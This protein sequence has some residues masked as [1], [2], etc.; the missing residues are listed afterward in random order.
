MD[1]QDK[2]DIFSKQK[3]LVLLGPTACGK[4]A[5]SL[6]I[7]QAFQA[8][9]ISADSMQVYRCMDIGTAKI[10][11]EEMLG[12]PHHLLDIR[13]PN[14]TFSVADFREAAS[15]AIREIAMRGH[16]PFLVGGTGL[17][18]N[19]LLRPYHFPDEAAA[20]PALRE[21]LRKELAEQGNLAMHKR[22]AEVD[23]LA[24]ARIHPNDAYRVLRALEV[25]TATGQT[26]SHLQ[27]CS[28]LSTEYD[29]LQIGLNLERELL[30]QR[31]ER[32]IDKM[33]A[34]GLVAEVHALLDAG[35]AREAPSMQGLGYRQIASYLAG[36][37]TLA[38]A[39]NRLKRDTRRFAKR[40]LTWFRRD[41]DI[42]WFYPDHYRERECLLHDVCALISSWLKEEEHEADR[43][44]G[45]FSQCHTQTA[46]PGNVLFDQ[47]V[48]DERAD[49]GI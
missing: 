47:R 42:H 27:A 22:L 17:Y 39:V 3:L 45:T 23:P 5:L 31:I 34:E 25:Y 24:A 33:M 48:S 11:A 14:Q 13:E 4:T 38:E 12:I 36:E 26:I 16:L 35:V 10:R 44:T 32:R 29:V 28:A 20:Q 8:E 43:T 19:S 41:P 1:K 21:R 9:V 18:I 37:C 6:R 2:H 15:I 30:Y 40:Q 46:D 7:A 49:Q